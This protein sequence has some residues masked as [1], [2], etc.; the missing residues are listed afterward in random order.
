[1]STFEPGQY[2]RLRS[3]GKRMLVI[4]VLETAQLTNTSLVPCEYQV[5]N[6]KTLGFYIAANLRL[7][8]APASP[9]NAV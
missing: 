4:H 6:R 9:G 8:D 3:G 5:K 2:V 7:A 1:M